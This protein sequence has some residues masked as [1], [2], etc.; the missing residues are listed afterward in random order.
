MV[1]SLLIKYIF[2]HFYEMFMILWSFSKVRCRSVRHCLT[3]HAS[4]LLVSSHVSV[5]VY[6]YIG[7]EGRLAWW[8][9]L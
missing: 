3:C 8:A 1:F 9:E 6:I 7:A 2:E 4:V 5:P